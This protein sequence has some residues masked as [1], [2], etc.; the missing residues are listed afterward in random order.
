MF[1][2]IFI[3]SYIRSFVSSFIHFHYIGKSFIYLFFQFRFVVVVVVVVVAVVFFFAIV[4][5]PSYEHLSFLLPFFLSFFSFFFFFNVLFTLKQMHACVALYLTKTKT[6]LKTENA[7][8][9]IN[10]TLK[11][12]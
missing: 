7:E 4:A 1:I 2:F 9:I 12:R 3:H 6:E 11:Q 8:N 10:T 5:R